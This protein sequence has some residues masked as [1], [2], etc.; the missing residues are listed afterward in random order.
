MCISSE[1]RLQLNDQLKIVEQNTDI[2][3]SH[4]NDIQDFFKR[5]SEIEADYAKK[6]DSL[7]EKYLL[8]HKQVFSMK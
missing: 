2:R 7:S 6:L 1:I 8:K 4:L 3:N 5:K